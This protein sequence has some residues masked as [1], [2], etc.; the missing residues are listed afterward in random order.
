MD[1]CSQA[2]TKIQ[3]L[4]RSKKCRTEFEQKREAARSIQRIF[5]WSH[6]YS[7]LA[8]LVAKAER[9]KALQNEMHKQSR[10]K[11][12]WRKLRAHAKILSVFRSR[13]N[14]FAE[15]Q[16][17]H[18][19]ALKRLE[20]EGKVSLQVDGKVTT[21]E[22]LDYRKQGNKSFYSAAA[23]LQRQ[24][25]KAN[26]GVLAVIEKF[27]KLVTLS[28]YSPKNYN[29]KNIKTASRTTEVHF[30]QYKLLMVRLLRV[31]NNDYKPS[32][33][34]NNAQAI[35]HEWIH[36]GGE[37]GSLSK[38]KFTQ[39][40]FELADQWVDSINA[41]DYEDFMYRLLWEIA[42]EWPSNK[43]SSLN[44]WGGAGSG[45]DSTGLGS[46][47]NG[48]EIGL[49][50]GPGRGSA[51]GASE[52]RGRRGGKKGKKG[53]GFFVWR[54]EEDVKCCVDGDGDLTFDR[55][56][57]RRR[58]RGKKDSNGSNGGSGSGTGPNGKDGI[59]N[60]NGNDDGNSGNGGNDNQS[61]DPSSAKSKWQKMMEAIQ[62]SRRNKR[63]GVGSSQFDS[64]SNG[65]PDGDLGLPWRFGDT[66]GFNLDKDKH[67][68]TIQISSPDCMSP[69]LPRRRAK[70]KPVPDKPKVEGYPNVRSVKTGLQFMMERRNIGHQRNKSMQPPPSRRRKRLP[71]RSSTTRERPEVQPNFSAL[72]LSRSPTQS[73]D[74]TFMTANSV[75]TKSYYSD[76]RMGGNQR[77]VKLRKRT[78]LPNLYYE[79]M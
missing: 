42:S 62:N 50:R 77:Q 5:R 29:P 17:A 18:L 28:G 19:D 1:E 27:W 49:G 37:A 69:L 63:L 11:Q 47:F 8:N 16:Q 70:R 54:K 72:Q 45:S 43:R 21:T 65:L 71:R 41:V 53:S 2:A 52:K 75:P 26:P 79:Q 55:A 60:G 68:S 40:I 35:Q 74:N 67:L 22:N 20:E 6:G 3:A 76:L 51:S 73:L 44:R 12:L 13:K 58:K 46:R 10:A 59:R 33:T 30:S 64:S 15:K 4:A 56:P 61:D 32:E 38:E 9:I 7:K 48:S 36:D 23:L 66:V 39:S 57:K 25:I 31:L 24:L 14:H 78:F 34:I